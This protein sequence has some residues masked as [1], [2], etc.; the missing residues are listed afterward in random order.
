MKMVP[1][2]VGRAGLKVQ[3]EVRKG[4]KAKCKKQNDP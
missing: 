1:G 3:C 2:E 4:E